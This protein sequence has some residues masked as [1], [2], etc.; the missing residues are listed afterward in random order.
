METC[1]NTLH[2]AHISELDI[3]LVLSQLEAEATELWVLLG[4][5]SLERQGLSTNLDEKGLDD[6]DENGEEVD[7]DFSTSSTTNDE[8]NVPS[9]SAS[10]APRLSLSL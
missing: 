2:E 7:P 6:E 9:T 3:H 8:L 5:P 1:L 10:Q 4:L